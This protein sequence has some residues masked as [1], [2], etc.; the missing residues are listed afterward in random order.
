MNIWD[1]TFVTS[2][3]FK[4]FKA[5]LKENEFYCIFNSLPT[6]KNRRDNITPFIL[7]YFSLRNHFL[8]VINIYTLTIKQS[9]GLNSLVVFLGPLGP[10]AVALYVCM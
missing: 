1:K 7:R 9:M 4:F 8:G 3:F 6:K 5:F 10:L 2:F